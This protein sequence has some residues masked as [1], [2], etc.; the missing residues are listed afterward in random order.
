MTGHIPKDYK[1]A[2]LT[3]II[4]EGQKDAASNYS[5]TPV[6]GK[7]LESIWGGLGSEQLEK[8]NLIRDGQCGGSRWVLTAWGFF[9]GIAAKGGLDGDGMMWT[10][11]F[12]VPNWDAAAE[13]H[14]AGLQNPLE[15]VQMRGMMDCLCQ[16]GGWKPDLVWRSEMKGLDFVFD[17][18]KVIKD[19]HT[20][21]KQE[22]G[23]LG[24]RARLWHPGKGL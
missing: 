2:N 19:H 21:E 13:F 4:Q 9:P 1:V 7:I 12:E 23:K 5:L 16:A 17:F 3:P 10:C 6:V 14:H 15:R 8:G 18:L 20:G 11:V 24:S 22:R